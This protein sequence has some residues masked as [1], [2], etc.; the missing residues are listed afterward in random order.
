MCVKIDRQ[1]DRY[2]LVTLILRFTSLCLLF[3]DTERR[4]HEKLPQS[5]TILKLGSYIHE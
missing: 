5:D 3:I 4:K 2:G 1:I